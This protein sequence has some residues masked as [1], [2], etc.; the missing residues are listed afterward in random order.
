MTEYSNRSTEFKQIAAALAKVQAALQ[1]AEKNATNP[2]FD[3]TYADLG[4]IWNVCRK[5]LAEN[6]IAIIQTVHH[7]GQGGFLETTLLHTSGEWIASRVPLMLQRQD[8]QGLGSAITY[9]RRY[10]LASAVGVAQEDDDG[11]DAGRGDEGKRSRSRGQGDAPEGGNSRPA[12]K[13]KAPNPAEQQEMEAVRTDID[14]ELQRL[15]QP[16]EKTAQVVKDLYKVNS[17]ADMT[18]AQLKNFL[19]RLKATATPAAKDQPRQEA[20]GTF[21]TMPTPEL[22]K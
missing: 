20:M 6:G 15:G 22:K 13:G 9:A 14:K 21:D 19:I 18:L 10:G 7:A 12:A 3:R 8:M 11:N 1:P 5:P 17:G 4:S 2:H 16:V